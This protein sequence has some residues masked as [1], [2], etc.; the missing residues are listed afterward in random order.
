MENRAG[1]A[2]GFG[3]GGFFLGML[4]GAVAGGITA[5]LLAPRPGPET[6]QMIAE[7][8]SQ[9]QDIVRTRAREAAHAGE[10]PGQQT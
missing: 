6:R 5:L 9:M 7:R 10:T 3:L 8:M 1:T 2:A 4:A